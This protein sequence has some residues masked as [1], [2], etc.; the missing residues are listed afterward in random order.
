M[1]RL[2]LWRLTAILLLVSGALVMPVIDAPAPYVAA[3][4]NGKNEDK[5]DKKEE[6]QREKEEK[7]REKQEKKDDK[8][9]NKNQGNGNANV[10]I[11]DVNGYTV[12]VRCDVDASAGTTTCS[13]TGVAPEGA[14]D[15]GHVDLPEDEVCAEVIGGSYEY[16]DPDPNTNV[17]G[18]KSTGDDGVITLILE[19]DVAPADTATYWFK[20]GDGVF[21]ATGPGLRCGEAAVEFTLEQ[22]PSAESTVEGKDVAE[23]ET[24]ELLILMYT[25]A[26]VPEDRTGYDWFGECD[27]EGGVHDFTLT[28]VSETAVEPV[29]M[30]SD[31]SGDVTFESLDPGLYSLEM[32][33]VTW[34]RAASDNVD[35]D[36]NINIVAGERTTVWGFI[37]Q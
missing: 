21:P 29:S 10:V 4:D 25:C 26:D 31:T 35:P 24:G 8:D 11:T 12:E 1:R 36:G 18:Y 19:G 34:C 13:F 5:A 37:C 27:P 17:T 14:K 28:E 22:T 23:P 33:D 7:E 30:Q 16:V 32:T 2:V 9:K 3:K 15:V 6:K 20:T